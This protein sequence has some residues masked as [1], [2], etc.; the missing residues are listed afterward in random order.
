MTIKYSLI[1]PCYNEELGIVDLVQSCKTLVNQKK[2]LEVVLINN[3]STDRTGILLEQATSKQSYD[4]IRVETVRSNKGYGYGILCG[5]KKARGT[6]VGWCHADLQTPPTR[7]LEAINLLE[8]EAEPNRIYI[9]GRR[10]NRD[11]FDKVFSVAMSCIEALLLGKYMP[12]INAQPNLFSKQF[13]ETW[14]KPPHDFSLDLYALL[15]A[16]KTGL[17][18]RRFPVEFL[19]RQ[20]GRGSNDGLIAKLKYSMATIQYSIKL[21]KAQRCDK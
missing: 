2:N 8:Y 6:Y 4:R 3:G 16:K 12:E 11:P 18:I 9:K 10:V 7:F 15:N 21:R 5:L 17:T 20:S 14:K 19:M 13:F 1:I